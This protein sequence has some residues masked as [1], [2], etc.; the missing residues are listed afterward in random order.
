M[1]DCQ[2]KADGHRRI[3]GI[4]AFL[5]DLPAH[6]AGQGAARHDQGVGRVEDSRLV[7][8]GPVRIDARGR[9]RCGSGRGAGHGGNKR[10][11]TGSEAEGHVGRVRGSASAELPQ[12]GDAT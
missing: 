4:A 9:G 11:K 8:Q 12:A 10:E 5:E 2:G 1:H 3:D 6:G 7:C